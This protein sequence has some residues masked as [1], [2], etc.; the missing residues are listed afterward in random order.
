MLPY[1]IL[2]CSVATL[3][4]LLN[5]HHRFGIPAAAPIIFNLCIIIA[6][7]F[8]SRSAS[9]NLWQQI[10]I[11]AF[12]VLVAGVLQFLLLVPSLAGS[13]ISLKPR[14]NFKDDALKK[15]MKL[16]APMLIGLSVVQFNVILDALIAFFLSQTPESGPSF[17]FMGHLVDYPVKEGS[18]SHLYLAARLYQFPLGVFAIALATAIFPHLSRQ[19]TEK[20]LKSFSNTLAQGIRMSIFIAIPATVGLIMVAE[21]LIQIIL[22][23]SDRITDEDTHLTAT[24]LWFYTLGLV[25]YCIQ[26]LIVRSFYAFQD[27]VTPVKVAVAMVGLNVILNLI[28]IWPLGT[29]GLALATAIGAAIQVLVLLRIVLR[30]YQLS[31]KQ[32]L[33]AT[34]IKTI[35]AAA[36]MALICH[37]TLNAIG[38]VPVWLEVSLIVVISAAVFAASSWL[39]KN[40]EVFA[41]FRSR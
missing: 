15:I 19:A 29:A 2:I 40:T 39:L 16:M 35:L 4:G 31:I 34:T 38:P 13:G 10:Y 11:V 23:W 8:L 36:I 17:T 33:V 25:A 30:R 20:D 5:V 21:P 24:T 37:F 41:L 1:M 14:F 18:L 28:L 27:S 9:E 32:G 12:A 3:S 6:V 7:Y 22:Q 26:P